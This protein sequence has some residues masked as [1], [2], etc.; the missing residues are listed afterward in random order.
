MK[1][2]WTAQQPEH[3]AR[4]VEETDVGVWQ[5]EGQWGDGRGLL[6]SSGEKWAAWGLESPVPPSSCLSLI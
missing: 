4:P 1:R 2:A 3:S 6:G 5:P